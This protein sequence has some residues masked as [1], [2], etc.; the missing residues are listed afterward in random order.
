M[1]N[2]ISDISVDEDSVNVTINLAS[3]FT[4][5]DN[6]DALITKAVNS[7][8]NPGLVNATISGNTLTL[9]FLPNQYGNSEIVIRVTS[10]GKTV[11]DTF[12]VT[13]TPV[14]DAPVVANPIS[15]VT[16]DEDSVNVTINLTSVFTDND[17]DD[18]LITKAVNSNSN[19]GL[20]NAAISGNTLSLNLL[21]D[22]HGSAVI[23]IRATSN[24]RSVNNSFTVSVT[25]LDDAPAI[26][27]PI[28][29]VTVDE[30]FS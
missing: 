17:N 6:D 2:P 27:N 10:N 19:P 23:V 4:D 25:P 24:G 13:V 9:S 5:I 28:S 12:T 20:V 16:V 22:Q 18:A 14:D 7:N 8:S 11:D 26:A 29:D 30:E 1:A 15:D 3:V 21:R